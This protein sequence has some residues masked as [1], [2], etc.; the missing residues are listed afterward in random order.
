MIPT[1]RL[2][3]GRR[4]ADPRTPRLRKRQG[5]GTDPA[6]SPRGLL[7]PGTTVPTEIGGVG[8]HVLVT[9]TPSIPQ[10][11]EGD[12]LDV[13]ASLDEGAA[14]LIY[15]DPPFSTGGVRRGTSRG[16]EAG[17]ELAYEDRFESPDA[18]LDFLGS[19]I[20]AMHRVLASDGA[21]L[22]HVDWRTS[23]RVRCI[24]DDVFGPDRFVNHI[25]W[26]YGLGG[27]SPTRFARKHDDIL[28]YARGEERWFDPPLV[29][30]TSRRL[31]GSLK[32]AT[33]VLDIPAI[34]NMA[35]ERTGWPDQ[36]PLA[37]LDLLVRACCPP[38][39][40]VIDPFC[41]SGTTLEAAMRSGRRAIGIDRSS[42]AIEVARDRLETCGLE[43]GQG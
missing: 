41:G 43:S 35:R 9:T 7:L 25:I 4:P 28:Y 37:L 42:A 26:H 20:E 33:D 21:I 32:K 17:R 5:K 34:N 11:I 14:S 12:C 36:K 16:V 2:I 38:D 29:P 8:H 23:H 1:T 22:I 15:A 24:L 3:R 18:Y 39:G 31:A 30:A 27:S 13:L 40:L 19:R 10:C 6:A